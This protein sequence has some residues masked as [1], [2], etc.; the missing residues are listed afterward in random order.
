[1]TMT[2]PNL[3]TFQALPVI[4]ATRITLSL[5]LHFFGLSR[6]Y[7]DIVGVSSSL[8][9]LAKSISIWYLQTI[10]F[11]Y[12]RSYFIYYTILFHNTPNIP[13]FILKYNTLK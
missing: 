12:L 1:M 5:K 6:K 8:V 11:Y 2:V 9:A 4:R 3:G 13:I 7:K 10:L